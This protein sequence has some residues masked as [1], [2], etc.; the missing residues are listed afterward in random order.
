MHSPRSENRH[1]SAGFLF[2]Q[3]SNTQ[4]TL[5]RGLQK[6]LWG[7]LAPH[8]QEHLHGPGGATLVALSG[9]VVGLSMPRVRS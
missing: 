1:L 4:W 6:P 7:E 5:Q 9:M 3:P 2:G 8:A